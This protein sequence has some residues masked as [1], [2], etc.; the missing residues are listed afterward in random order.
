[1]ILIHRHEE[2]LQ[3][4]NYFSSINMTSTEIKLA[5]E[6]NTG[7][8]ILGIL[9]GS[10][11]YTILNKY[12]TSK[13]GLYNPPKDDFNQYIARSAEGFRLKGPRIAF[14]NETTKTFNPWVI[15]AWR[16]NSPKTYYIMNPGEERYKDITKNT[17]FK[18]IVNPND[19][20]NPFNIEEEKLIHFDYQVLFV[21]E[22][23]I[24]A[25]GFGIDLA[26]YDGLYDNTAFLTK[27]RDE[28][29]NII[30]KQCGFDGSETIELEDKY[31]ESFN[32]PPLYKILKNK[33]IIP[34]SSSDLKTVRPLFNS[35]FENVRSFYQ[36]HTPDFEFP[37]NFDKIFDAKNSNMMPNF[38]KIVLQD[39]KDKNLFNIRFDCRMD[40]TIKIPE[41]SP[42]HNPRIK[43]FWVTKKQ[44]SSTKIELLSLQSMAELWGSSDVA[45]PPSF[46]GATHTGCIFIVPSIELKYYSTG[47]PT[48]NWSVNK[49]A[50]KKKTHATIDSSY[51]GEFV[52]DEDSEDL[53]KERAFEEEDI[54]FSL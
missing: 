19:K 20:E 23:L 29:Y 47:H 13:C 31:V 8:S 28:I 17:H 11:S 1:M 15:V 14:K 43:D 3:I 46:R 25:H 9:D 42:G 27:F 22:C 5:S 32:N 33:S 50:L 52:G 49:V 45:K 6:L 7:K 12:F 51:G 37:D 40:F 44:V 4:N 34:I 26:K 39:K 16:G 21:M 53:D 10:E 2:P 36:N 30:C 24:M 41:G 38:R 54:H 18:L 35:L 48:I